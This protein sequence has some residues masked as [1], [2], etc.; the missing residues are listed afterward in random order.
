M[1]QKCIIRARIR[2]TRRNIFRKNV[3]FI[4]FFG[5]WTEK[6]QTFTGKFWPEFRKTFYVSRGLLAEQLFWMRLFK[7]LGFKNF[8][9][10]FTDSGENF[11]QGFQ[12]CNK[13]PEEQIEEKPFR[14][15]KK[16]TTFKILNEL[17]LSFF[18]C[19]SLAELSKLQFT[20]PCKVM[21]K[22]I[23]LK[24][25]TLFQTCLDFEPKK[26]TFSRKASSRV[27]TTAICAS[28]VAFFKKKSFL[29]LYR[30][31]FS[32]RFW[33]LSNIFVF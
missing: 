26:K 30:F 15:E 31:L 19:R 21:R 22:K 29:F 14:I 2:K 33:N 32:L 23:F 17:S 28:I 27:V 1:S 6:L 9:W 5:L 20:S 25:W 8:K 11:F 13:C 16:A 12:N 3:I 10:S 4:Y 24:H 7:K 18:W